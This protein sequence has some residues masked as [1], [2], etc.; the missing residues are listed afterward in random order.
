MALLQRPRWLYPL[1][2]LDFSS[3]ADSDG[4]ETWLIDQVE[5]GFLAAADVGTV[6]APCKM[7]G[8]AARSMVKVLA[9]I[10]VV[11][12]ASWLV[13]GAEVSGALLGEAYIWLDETGMVALFARALLELAGEIVDAAPAGLEAEEGAEDD[14]VLEGISEIGT[15]LPFP[16]PGTQPGMRFAGVAGAGPSVTA[17][18]PGKFDN[19]LPGSTFS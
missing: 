1:F 6:D 16:P 9:G 15:A 2:S 14:A 17:T 12:A 5:V 7:S 18:Q 19:T 10:W 11:E 3:L 8:A 4:T 13:G